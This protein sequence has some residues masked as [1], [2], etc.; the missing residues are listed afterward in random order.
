MGNFRVCHWIVHGEVGV[1]GW[2][3]KGYMNQ[4]W[5]RV[6]MRILKNTMGHGMVHK[7]L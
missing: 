4:A 7:T 3:V 5:L 1:V 6:P 2:D